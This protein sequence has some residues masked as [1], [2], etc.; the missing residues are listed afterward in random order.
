MPAVS[1]ARSFST[2]DILDRDSAEQIL[3]AAVYEPGDVEKG[4]VAAAMQGVEL[5]VGG[6]DGPPKHY[7]CAY[8]AK[9]N[10]GDMVIFSF[11]P[12]A[13]KDQMVEWQ[14]LS[15]GSDAELRSKGIERFVRSGTIVLFQQDKAAGTSYLIWADTTGTYSLSLTIKSRQKPDVARLKFTGRSLIDKVVNFSG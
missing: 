11:E 2:C 12:F 7:S 9:S 14:K 4:H 8:F 15:S 5:D 3:G 6:G 10:D 13:K 1:S